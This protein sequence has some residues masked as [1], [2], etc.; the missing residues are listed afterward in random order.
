MKQLIVVDTN[1][2]FAALQNK[3]NKIRAILTN[4]NLIFY[5][6][7]FLVVEVFKHKERILKKA[8][9]T[10]EEILELLMLLIQQIKF[11]PE[12]HIPTETIIHAFRLCKGEDDKDTLFV[13]LALEYEALLWTRDEKLKQHLKTQ[14]F[15]AFFDEYQ[16]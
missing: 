9:S 12:A 3:S 7:N 2:L 8:S 14:G 1:I 16:L 15:N 5:A 6:P 11:V 10:E 13:A 4:P